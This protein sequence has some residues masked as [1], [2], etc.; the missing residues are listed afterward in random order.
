MKL[1][2][3]ILRAKDE[4]SDTFKKLANA[5]GISENKIENVRRKMNSTSQSAAQMNSIFGTLKNTLATVFT[6]GAISAL[7]MGIVKAGSEMEQTTIAYRV[8]LQDVAQADSKIKELQKFADVS[9]F[10]TKEVMDAGQALLGFG[11]KSQKLLP[12]MNMLGDASMG[13][14]N[15]FKSLVD[16][17]GKMVSAQ[18]ANTMDLNQFAIQGIPVWQKLSDITG[19]SGK[20]LRKYVE[21]N[22]VGL[23][24]INKIFGDLT[25][26]GGQFFGM[27]TEQSKSTLGIWSTFVSKL[28]AIGIRI[29]NAFQPVINAAI[30]F[31]T[32]LLNNGRLL[33]NIALTVGYVASVFLVY[34]A[35]VLATNLA[36]GAYVVVTNIARMATILFAGGFG[37]L[38]LIMQLNPI[39][40]IVTALFALTAA[41]VLAYQKVDWFRGGIWG[42]WEASKQVFTNI[43]DL[44]KRIFDPFFKAIDAF[45]K[46]DFAGAAKFT[47]QGLYDLTPF[48][49]NFL[50]SQHGT[51]ITNGVGDAFDKGYKSGL[52]KTLKMPSWAKSLAGDSS[53]GETNPSG[54][55][56]VGGDAKGIVDNITSG[57][58]K[59]TNVNIN[60]IKFA[61]TINVDMANK[62]E[63]E[64]LEKQ[65]REF[66]ARVING[67][68]YGA[69][70]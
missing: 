36:V 49:K 70:Q 18:R 56:S 53:T 16:N 31:G 66:F 52:G 7:T 1:Y 64:G 26:K 57:G 24:T 8:L 54:D 21:D 32:E 30:L 29:F 6:V 35:V 13:N 2:E 65:F 5:A 27:M 25:G 42:L 44:F 4:F 47:A 11:V 46:G 28:E 67:G 69:T 43:G 15:K 34:K 3:Y 10:N 50:K 9:P 60:G 40:L 12:I 14:S 22:G 51:G 61:E 55:L 45:K 58:A 19:L 23:E 48:S 59:H 39:A 63:W 17:Y 20:A 37:K 33:M 41:F 68:V 38:N 62:Q